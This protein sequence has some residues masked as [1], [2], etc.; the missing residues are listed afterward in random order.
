MA[1]PSE[2]NLLLSFASSPKQS[3]SIGTCIS[4]L[5]LHQA[6]PALCRVRTRP[7]WSSRFRFVRPDEYIQLTGC[8]TVSP[9]RSPASFG[10]RVTQGALLPC[11]S[12][13]L[14]SLHRRWLG[15]CTR[16]PQ[17]S[18]SF[19]LHLLQISCVSFMACCAWLVSCRCHGARACCYCHCCCV[20]LFPPRQPASMSHSTPTGL[21]H[22]PPAIN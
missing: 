11:P 5:Q 6:L 10:T 9:G 2:A 19:S 3:T 8:G 13:R 18:G 15:A 12:S 14:L 20:C 4:P 17:A 7:P 16:S 21:V 22:P 1:D